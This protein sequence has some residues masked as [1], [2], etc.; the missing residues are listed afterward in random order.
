MEKRLF[1]LYNKSKHK[2]FD[3]SYPKN[4]LSKIRTKSY[5]VGQ[6]HRS[7]TKNFVGDISFD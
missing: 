6:K 5:C 1:L 4:E 7:A 2:N 3:T